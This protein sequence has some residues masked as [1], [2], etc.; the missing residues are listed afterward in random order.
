MRIAWIGTG[1]MGAPMAGHLIEAGHELVVSTRTASR[2]KPLLDRGATWADSPVGAADG[3]DVAISIVGFPPDVEEV[4]LGPRGTLSA[5]SLP[6]V[7]V[8]MTTSRPSL[9]RRIA[10]TAMVHGVGCVDAPVSGG[11]VGARTASLS[12]MIGGED[13]HVATVMPLMEAM[14]SRIVHHGPP[15][16]GQ[17]CKMVNQILIAAS[18][19]GTIEGLRYAQTAGLD[20]R[21]VL[22]SV[23][24][25]AAG[26]W[27]IDN[28][29]PR[30]L[31]GDY[32]PG[33]LVD[34]FLKDLRIALEEAQAMGLEL[35]G[36]TLARDAYARLSEQGHS[37]C[38]THALWLDSD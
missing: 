2:A 26:S 24:A 27:T 6:Q 32:A 14:G 10:E 35:P 20:G 28:L 9:A 12:I 31:E 4:H 1:V 25:G 23:S 3:A 17:H 7:I 21:R 22:E 34:H 5:G 16:T 29:A 13:D 19:I 11:D 18:M 36:L 33:F 37:H 38:G 30:I 15:G 8:D